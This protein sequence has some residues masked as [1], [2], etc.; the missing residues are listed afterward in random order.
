MVTDEPKKRLPRRDTEARLSRHHM[1]TQQ[2]VEI[3][4]SLFAERLHIPAEALVERVNDGESLVSKATIYNTLG[5]FATNGLVKE[6]RVDCSKVFYDSNPLAHHHFYDTI[7]GELADFDPKDIEISKLP[8][9][10]PGT[11]LDEIEVIIQV[12]RK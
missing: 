3:A 10:P 6:V 9:P 5:L 1:P 8:S 7:T 2:R 11:S 12:S 4:S